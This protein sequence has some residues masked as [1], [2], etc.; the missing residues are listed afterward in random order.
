MYTYLTTIKTKVQ[1]EHVLG[2]NSQFKH[3][4]VKVERIQKGQLD[5][6]LTTMIV[7]RKF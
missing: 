1:K 6:K 5:T 7:R 3:K 4:F 2:S